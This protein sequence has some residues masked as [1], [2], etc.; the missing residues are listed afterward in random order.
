MSKILFILLLI[1]I[2]VHAQ[3]PWLGFTFIQ[4]GAYPCSL[5]VESI[6]ESS[7][8]LKAG[9]RKGDI[10]YTIDGSPLRGMADL[11]ERMR[12][13]KVGQTMQLQLMR[14]GGK[15]QLNVKL[16]ARPDDLRRFTGSHVGS[17]AYALDEYFYANQSLIKKKPKVILMDYWATWCGPC[18]ASIP[19]LRA[20]YQEYS[21]QGFELIGMSGEELGVLKDFQAMEKVPWP[22]YQDKGR[23]QAGHWGVRAVPTL[24]LLNEDWIVQKIWEG[25][26]QPQDLRNWIQRVLGAKP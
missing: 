5:Q 10:I 20:V 15:V 13:A 2:G 21:S 16:T 1:V 26:P 4:R 9:L 23:K 6:H 7:G 8:A 25:P 19:M 14:Q 11:Q 24:I 12:K 18:R 22:L 17:K 3:N